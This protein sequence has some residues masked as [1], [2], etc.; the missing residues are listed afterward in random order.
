MKQL[1]LPIGYLQL[2]AA[3]VSQ[4]SVFSSDDYILA[5][6]IFLSMPGLFPA[7]VSKLPWPYPLKYLSKSFISRDR[8]GTFSISVEQADY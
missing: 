2:L 8:A 3:G 7:S 6:Y 4:F 1:P 5:G